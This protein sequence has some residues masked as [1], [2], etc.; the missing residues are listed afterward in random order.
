LSRAQHST[1]TPVARPLKGIVLVVLAGCLLSV[2]DTLAKGLS[3]HYPVQMVAWARYV[4]HVLLML[5]V[6]WPSWRGR[7]VQT[8]RP[9]L[10]LAR[11][12]A[13]GLSSL[14]FFLTLSSMP[15]AEATAIVSVCP[16]LTVLIAV[17]WLGET[18]PRGTWLALALSFL[19]VLLIIRPGSA[20]FN[21]AAL[22]ALATAACLS[23]YQLLTRRLAGV[24]ASVATLFIGALVPAVL[25]SLILPWYWRAPTSLSDALAMAGTGV[26]G[27]AGHLLLVRGY[28]F[29]SASTLAPFGYVQAVVALPLGWF[30]FRM[31]PD[32]PALA[33]MLAIVAS[34][35][36]MALAHRRSPR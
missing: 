19:G 4:F 31:F 32:G 26:V 34:G 23:A 2:L 17:R 18:A 20:L 7:L 9:G 16:I 29:A 10:Q 24:D 21:V 13:L 11:G 22:S 33:G 27:A 25:F 15:Q 28:A 36:G 30:V 14:F 5:A 12:V 6:L 8:R 35:V 3:R 1:Q